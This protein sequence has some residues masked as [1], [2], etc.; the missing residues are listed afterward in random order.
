MKISHLAL[1]LVALALSS[2][3]EY[4]YKG[5]YQLAECYPSAK[6]KIDQYYRQQK[7]SFNLIQ[8]QITPNIQE[9]AFRTRTSYS[10]TRWAPDI[11]SQLLHEASLSK[12]GSAT[13]TF[14]VGASGSLYWG[15][16]TGGRVKDIDDWVVANLKVRR[17]DFGEQRP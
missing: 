2:C 15:A 11:G 13:S 7:K 17:R 8:D 4:P 5:S 3:T 12:T 14:E 9:N 16:S 1:G 10:L 6:S